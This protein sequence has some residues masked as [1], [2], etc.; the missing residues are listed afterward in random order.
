MRYRTEDAEDTRQKVGRRTGATDS[1][2]PVEMEDRT[3]KRKCRVDCCSENETEKDAADRQT[4]T[5][6][7]RWAEWED[8]E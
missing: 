3:R 8:W 7:T 6:I 5:L 1:T 4:W 2:V